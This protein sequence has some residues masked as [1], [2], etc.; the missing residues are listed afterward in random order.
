MGFISFELIIGSAHCTAGNVLLSEQ[1][2][3]SVIN[4]RTIVTP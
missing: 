1:I 4:V 3:K 2:N